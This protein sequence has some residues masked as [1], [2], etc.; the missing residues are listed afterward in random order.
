MCMTNVSLFIM[1]DE[2]VNN[3]HAHRCAVPKGRDVVT[4]LMNEEIVSAH[5][6]A[7]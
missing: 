3:R 4:Y 7:I 2:C 6:S 5:Y 1:S